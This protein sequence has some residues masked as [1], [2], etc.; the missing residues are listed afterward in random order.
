MS[1]TLEQLNKIRQREE[2]LPQALR[3]GSN[4]NY[5]EGCFFVTLNTRSEAPILSTLVGSPDAP[6]G[7]PNAPRC[8][9]STL[10]SKVKENWEKIPTI[11]PY[12]KTF[13]CEVMP[14]HFHG[15]IQLLPGNEMH[16]GHIIG[17]FMGACSHAYWDALGIDWRNDRW[18]KAWAEEKRAKQEAAQKE[19]G[20]GEAQQQE[21]THGEA[22]QQDRGHA[23]ACLA[24]GGA[25]PSAS[26]SVRAAGR[27]HTRC[28]TDRD[29]DHTHS[30][31]GPALFVRG[32]NDVE[33]ITP[34]QIAI[35]QRYIGEQARRALIKRG[36]YECFR[37][38]RDSTAKG[39]TDEALRQALLHDRYLA[40]DPARLQAAL[41]QLR[42]R[43]PMHPTNGK[44]TLSYIGPIAL[45]AAPRKLPL[46]CHRADAPFF[47][48]QK[49]AVMRAA[50][51]E[52]A[53]IV[54][55]FI[56]PKEREI[57]R[58]LLAEMLPVVEVVDNG[59]ADRYKPSG[60]AFYACAENRLVQIS[61]WTHEYS[62]EG[63]VTRDMCM[64][65]NELVRVITGVRDDW[66]K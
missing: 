5:Y 64:V 7:S 30:F 51:E 25:A 39:W 14:D 66:W 19:A 58:L 59:F 29:R 6:D 9:Y 26:P 42:L 18:A 17:G 65:M 50:C 22:Q 40:R 49:E 36:T 37:I 52:R 48:R 55:A 57:Q 28:P 13:E 3:R 32:Y 16:L 35:K 10:G 47:E 44:P 12:I 54:S 2:S 1:L 34:E 63:T 33:A 11:R 15:L 53:V 61:P 27:S 4:N 56:S 38:H 62:R 60:R 20:H 21:A 43:I 8:E 41:Q 46:I 24:T 45:L 31:R 23:N